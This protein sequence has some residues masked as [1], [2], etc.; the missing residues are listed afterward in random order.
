MSRGANPYLANRARQKAIELC[1]EDVVR[2]I[3]LQ[4]INHNGNHKQLI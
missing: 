2:E 3:I 4:R 1:Q